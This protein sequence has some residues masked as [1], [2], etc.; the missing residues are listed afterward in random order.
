MCAVLAVYSSERLNRALAQNWQ[1][2]AGQPYFDENGIFISAVL[3]A[4]LVLDM[5]VILVRLRLLYTVL[6]VQHVA[7]PHL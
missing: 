5:L 1:T 7:Q 6:A 2:F 4:P 3:S